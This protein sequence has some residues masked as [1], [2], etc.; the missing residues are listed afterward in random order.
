METVP[1]ST[2]AP[3]TEKGG[4]GRPL[5]FSLLMPIALVSAL[6]L[7]LVD[8][9]E[10]TERRLNACIGNLVTIYRADAA[11][12]KAHDD[13]WPSNL[14]AL[15]DEGLLDAVP[16]CPQAKKDTYSEGY[17]PEPPASGEEKDYLACCVGLHH[18][19]MQ[20]NFPRISRSGSTS[21]ALW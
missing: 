21:V 12:R 9:N 8:E 10:Q 7:L 4:C 1:S 5:L 3:K 11:Y 6:F 13:A 19:H 17:R 18:P 14:Q 16:I 15:V 20:D 2:K